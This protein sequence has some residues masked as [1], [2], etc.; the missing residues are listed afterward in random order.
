MIDAAP[1]GAL[2]PVVSASLAIKTCKFLRKYAPSEH[3]GRGNGRAGCHIALMNA[4]RDRRPNLTIDKASKRHYQVVAVSL[5]DDELEIAD[6]LT[7]LLRTAGWPAA[8][9]SFVIREAL[10]CLNDELRDASAEDVLNYF[11]ASHTGRL[12]RSQTETP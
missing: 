3:R 10:L 7:R 12:K 9:R 5:Y 8:N 11:V 6:R 1:F 4:D 2:L